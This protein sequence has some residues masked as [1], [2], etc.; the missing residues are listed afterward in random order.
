MEPRPKKRPRGAV[1]QSENAVESEQQE[2]QD[3]EAVFDKLA[4]DRWRARGHSGRPEPPT[5]VYFKYT[6]DKGCI[7]LSGLSGLDR[8]FIQANKISLVI[9]CVRGGASARGYEL[10]KEVLNHVVVITH[11]RSR[12]AEMKKAIRVLI[13]T[14]FAG[15]NAVIHCAA[16]VH[17]APV[18]ASI[19]VACIS[20]TTLEQAMSK[21]EKLR[22]VELHKVMTGDIRS[23]AFDMSRSSP[24]VIAEVSDSAAVAWVVSQ[25]ARPRVHAEWGGSPLCRRH[26]QATSAALTSP[27]RCASLREA[28][29]RCESTCGACFEKLPASILAQAF[30]ISG[31]EA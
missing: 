30:D 31:F 20:G 25:G 12:T 1:Q 23:W 7:F 8:D 10:P 11:R 3:P 14:T 24:P 4:E 26:R 17:R 21:I 27:E 18:G 15:E 19:A 29:T 13:A 5:L 28:L 6:K 2:V 9:S 16:G 22:N